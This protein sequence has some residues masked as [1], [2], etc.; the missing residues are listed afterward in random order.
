MAKMTGLS[1]DVYRSVLKSHSVDDRCIQ[2]SRKIE[3]GFTVRFTTTEDVPYRQNL[4]FSLKLE[5]T[6]RVCTR[7]RLVDGGAGSSSSVLYD[8]ESQQS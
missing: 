2:T 4:C 3:Y 1:D 6:Q 7:R 8:G 5:Q